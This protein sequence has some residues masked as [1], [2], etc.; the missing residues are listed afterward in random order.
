MKNRNFNTDGL[1]YFEEIPKV[2]EFFGCITDIYALIPYFGEAECTPYFEYTKSDNLSSEKLPLLFKRIDDEVA[3]EVYTNIPFLFNVKW[4]F[5]D[6]SDSKERMK[7]FTSRFDKYKKIGLELRNKEYIVPND[8][9]KLKYAKTIE[10]KG[11]EFKN[12]LEFMSSKAHSLFNEKTKDIV[13]RM[14]SIALVDNIMY[15][16]NKK[17]KVK[18]LTKSADN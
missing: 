15:E 7:E 9:F 6:I 13:D 1:V 5:S 12:Y 14:H 8:S 11:E 4:N 18:E 10:K 2:G 17:Y 3:V 16:A